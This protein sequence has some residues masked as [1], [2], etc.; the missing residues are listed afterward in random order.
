M[1]SH[2]FLSF[3]FLSQWCHFFSSTNLK[4]YCPCCAQHALPKIY[5]LLFLHGSLLCQMQFWFYYTSGF[6]SSLLSHY[7]ATHQLSNRNSST[8]QIAL[9]MAYLWALRIYSCCF[10]R[11][12]LKPS[13]LWRK[14]LK[15]KTM[16]YPTGH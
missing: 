4:S 9:M 3:L 5:R 13:S 6:S 10:F 16:F 8:R 15:T 1:H 7:K 14:L 11:A 2:Q 12:G